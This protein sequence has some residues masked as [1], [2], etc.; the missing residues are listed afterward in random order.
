MPTA[1]VVHAAAPAAEYL[2]ESQPWHMAEAAADA[3]PARHS[4]HT[5]APTFEYFPA[6]QLW[7]EAEPAS[8][9]Y[10]PGS[11]AEHDTALKAAW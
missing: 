1:Q 2:P 8:D 11:H 7:H 10:W 4:V 6:S 9:W 3:L 5:D